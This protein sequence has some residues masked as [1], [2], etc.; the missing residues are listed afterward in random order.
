MWV[1]RQIWETL[2]WVDTATLALGI[3]I[4][5]AFSP[6]DPY[7]GAHTHTHTHRHNNSHVH[8]FISTHQH[9]V[10]FYV[11]HSHTLNSFLDCLPK[12]NGPAVLTTQLEEGLTSNLWGHLINT[13]TPP[14]DANDQPMNNMT[15]G[16]YGWLMN[17]LR[18]FYIFEH[19]YNVCPLTVLV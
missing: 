16:I 7:L 5:D 9:K 14:W 6:S 19:L 2:D 17:W 11:K 13:N 8:M 3:F 4:S 15:H 10:F 1:W 18:S 12:H